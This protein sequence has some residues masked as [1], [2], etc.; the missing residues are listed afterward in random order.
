[1][2]TVHVQV[3]RFQA[4]RPSRGQP[5]QPVGAPAGNVHFT[6]AVHVPVAAA[7]LFAPCSGNTDSLLTAAWVD[8]VL[9]LTDPLSPKVRDAAMW[10]SK[11]SP[12]ADI[13]VV[14]VRWGPQA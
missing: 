5:A 1:M 7:I 3:P 10:A 2:P 6:L 14:D 4:R 13:S 12:L 8:R 11:L 9:S